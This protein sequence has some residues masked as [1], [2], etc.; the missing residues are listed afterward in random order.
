MTQTSEEAKKADYSLRFGDC[1]QVMPSLPEGSVD[2]IVADLPYG[3]TDCTWDSPINLQSMWREFRRLLR[4]RGCVVLHASQP[5]TSALVM[6]NPKWFKVEWIWEKN[7]GSN[8]GTV[9]WQPMKE[10]ESV[11]V[12]GNETVTYNPIME[13]R[14]ASGLARVKTVV[15][16]NT[17]PEVYQ[18]GALNGQESSKRPELRFPRSI[19]KFNR[20]RGLHPTQKPLR[21]LAYIIRTYSH[22]GAMVLDPTMG[23]GTTGVAALALGRNFS[24]IELDPTYFMVAKN[25]IEKTHEEAKPAALE[26][27]DILATWPTL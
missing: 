3:T 6:S 24:G 1:L 7:A 14:T 19:Q 2:L 11:L 15:N 9:R 27:L 5:F 4:P 23:S 25:R 16:Y 20:E 18:S 21:L 13:P 10:H 8:F 22:P 26:F 12:F 17:K